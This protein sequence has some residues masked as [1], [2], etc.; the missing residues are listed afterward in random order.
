[1]PD[2][3]KSFFEMHKAGINLFLVIINVFIF[4]GLECKELFFGKEK[5]SLFEIQ[6]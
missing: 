2:G 1:M 5:K 3:V 6:L 4:P